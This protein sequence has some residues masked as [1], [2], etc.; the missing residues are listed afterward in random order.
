MRH[1][2]LS[3][4]SAAALALAGCQGMTTE[5]Q[6]IVGG[7][8]GAVLGVVTAEALDA[9]PQWTILA[10]LAGAAAGTLVARNNA[11]DNCAYAKGDGTY[12][13]RRCP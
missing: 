8:T 10:V 7:L 4:V 12:E 11:E 13:I 3:I 5:E 6:M 1:Q 2:I 9:N